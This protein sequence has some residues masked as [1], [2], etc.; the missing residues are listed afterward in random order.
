LIG[1]GESGYDPNRTRCAAF[2]S[3]YFCHFRSRRALFRLGLRLIPAQM[4]NEL[5]FPWN[6]SEVMM[7][8]ADH[9]SILKSPNHESLL[10]MIPEELAALIFKGMV[11]RGRELCRTLK[12]LMF[13][14]GLPVDPLI[15]RLDL[16]G[17]EDESSFK[18]PT[19]ELVFLKNFDHLVMH[20]TT[21]RVGPLFSETMLLLSEINLNAAREIKVRG[22]WMGTD[23]VEHLAQGLQS[24]PM[25]QALDVSGNGLGRSVGGVEHLASGLKHLTLLTSLHVRDN[26]LGIEGA[27]Q[28]SK[29]LANLRSLMLLE[30]GYNNVG[31][32]GAKF[33]ADALM[34]TNSLT[35]LDMRDN[36][37]LAEGARQISRCLVHLSNLNTLI[38]GHNNLGAAGA[39]HLMHGMSNLISLTC[40][41]IRDNHLGQSGAEHLA[42]GLEKTLKLVAL[43]VGWNE[44][45]RSGS[46]HVADALVN[47]TVL[48]TLNM[49]GNRI[50]RSGAEHVTTTLC[51]LYSLKCINFR[52]DLCLAGEEYIRCLV[53][54]NG[55]YVIL[56]H[57]CGV[58]E[59]LT[60]ATAADV[61]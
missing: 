6:S 40:I 17:T 42:K 19:E 37:L 57:A 18:N 50:G 46:V 41:N 35:Y 24:L 49:E 12:T 51:H 22:N 3:K 29:G 53:G 58:R 47:K 45:R 5:S 30:V 8:H 16:R 52:C 25:L 38:L 33:I 7:T 26:F 1:H 34:H 43:D 31:A 27:E 60:R 44:L 28:L 14:C 36:C 61:A 21:D 20:I 4:D 32:A 9:S 13:R 59:Q 10:T 23:A 11:L 2:E 54:H 56:S 55:A 15:F 39:E 48:A